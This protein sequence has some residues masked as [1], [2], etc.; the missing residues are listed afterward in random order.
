MKKRV[1]EIRAE[2]HG[3]L[4]Q[5]GDNNTSVMFLLPL[6]ELFWLNSENGKKQIKSF[7]WKGIQ[8]GTQSKEQENGCH[9]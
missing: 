2:G 7:L 4:E 9:L 1:K 3:R 6:K 8:G 5:G